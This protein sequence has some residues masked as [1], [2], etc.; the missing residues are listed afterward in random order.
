MDDKQATLISAAAVSAINFAS[1]SLTED[2]TILFS[3]ISPIVQVAIERGLHAIGANRLSDR[4]KLRIGSAVWWAHKVAEENINSGKFIKLNQYEGDDVTSL[5]ESIFR[6]ASEDSQEK[7][8]MAYGA[9]L[10]NFAFQDQFDRGALFSMARILKDLSYDE[11]LLIAAL[12]GQSGRNYEPF[13]EKLDNEEDLRCGEMVGYFV[14]LR[15]LGI[16]KRVAPFRLGSSI[17]NLKLSA[18]GEE[19][20]SQARLCDM[21]VEECESLRSY[22]NMIARPV[23]I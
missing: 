11:L 18:L 20:C 13:Y 3:A 2:F 10:G 19:L 6:A 5:V 17:G 4:E 21:D 14:R 9:F 7:K 16:T 23:G 22:I 8:D 12:S 15:N 1:L